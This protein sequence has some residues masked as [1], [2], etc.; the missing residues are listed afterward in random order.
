LEIHIVR[1]H[2]LKATFLGFHFQEYFS[3][4]SEENEISHFCLMNSEFCLMLSLIVHGNASGLFQLKEV[5]RRLKSYFVILKKLFTCSFCAGIMP[6]SKLIEL[7]L[8]AALGSRLYVKMSPPERTCERGT[9]L[10]CLPID[11]IYLAKIRQEVLRTKSKP[12]QRTVYSY[13]PS[14]VHTLV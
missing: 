12:L 4:R 5:I 13:L 6:R 1:T 14:A 7:N 9:F 3:I 8:G 11:L 2:Y 10:Y